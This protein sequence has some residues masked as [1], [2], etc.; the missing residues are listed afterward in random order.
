MNDGGVNNLYILALLEIL[1][2]CRIEAQIKEC[3]VDGL[4]QVFI[5][6]GR[7]VHANQLLGNCSNK[8]CHTI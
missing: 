8:Y 4:L 5:A 3:H 7:G 6:V 1:L 2:C